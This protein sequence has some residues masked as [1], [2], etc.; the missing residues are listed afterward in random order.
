MSRKILNYLGLQ[1]GW[2]ACAVGAA[3][4]N[5]WIGPL[6][7]AGHTALHL[8]G[9]PRPKREARLLLSAGML[10]ILIDSLKKTSGLV[11]YKTPW[12][13]IWWLAPLWI[14]A[15]WVLFATSLTTSLSWLQGRPLLQA[16]L[17]ALGGPL[18]YLAGERLGAIAFYY[19]D[20]ITLAI[21]AVIW[22]GAV[23]LL[24]WL[25]KRNTT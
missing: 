8:T 16:A 20:W 6:I 23:P 13:D 12:P 14:T 19:P 4:G 3:R 18:S 1:I 15:M 21:L 11:L 22:A 17:G 10:G 5:G 2:L 9:I 7:V 24:F 25:A